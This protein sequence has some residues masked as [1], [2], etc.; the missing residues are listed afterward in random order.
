MSERPQ[1]IRSERYG[2]TGAIFVASIFTS[3]FLLFMIQPVLA[4]MLLPRYGGTPGVWNTSIVFFQTVLLIGYVY[5]HWGLRWLGERRFIAAHVVVL[6]AS[7]L[8]LPPRLG[9]AAVPTVSEWP[10]GQLLAS[11]AVTIAIPFF[12]L[13]TNSSLVQHW[14]SLGRERAHLDP[15]RLYAASN[16]GSLLAL[17]GYPFFIEPVWRIS[18][19]VWIWTFGYGLF[20]A[21][22]IAVMRMVRSARPETGELDAAQSVSLGISQG[23]V[24][25][26]AEVGVAA[27][28]GQQISAVRRIMWM[29]RA[30]VAVSLLLSVTVVITTDIAPVPLLWV[31]PLAIY[32]L[33]FILAFASPRFYPQRVILVGSIVCIIASLSTALLGIPIPLVVALPVALL[34]LFFGAMLCHGD[35]A[36]DRP[37][38]THLTEYYLWVA[39]GG[40]VGGSLN[41]IVAPL[42]FESIAEYPLTLLALSIVAFL[43]PS[44]L[45]TRLRTWRSGALSY[46]M[47][48]F[49]VALAIWAARVPHDG[50]YTMRLIAL[51]IPQ[52]ILVA[53]LASLSFLR[54]SSFLLSIA[55]AAIFV[56]GGISESADVIHQAR[57]FFGVQRVVETD[58]ARILI[59]GSTMHGIQSKETERR[60]IPGTYYHPNAPMGTLIRTADA[61]AAIGIIGLGAGSLAALSQ[62]RQTFVFHEI[63]P[64][65]LQIARDYFTFLE[66]SAAEVDIVLGDGRLTLAD[67][68]DGAYDILILDAFSSDSVPTHLL[69]VEAFELYREK[70]SERGVIMVH[71]SN[72]HIDLARIVRGVAGAADLHVRTHEYSPSA[73][74][75]RE[76][77]SA[78]H[79]ALLSSSLQTI[80][81]FADAHAWRPPD[82]KAP[83]TIWTDD[84]APIL[85][86]LRWGPAD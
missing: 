50:P 13:S 48:V 67:V 1:S 30:A 57:S 77:A 84:H 68:P 36:R 43:G 49:M 27:V 72:R 40:V 19:Q 24:Q 85:G 65:V 39:L 4:R 44:E 59:H 28:G 16:A 58:S 70:V 55:I 8:M 20:V 45:A 73:D 52:F 12:V 41:S 46:V 11:L 79:V 29:I 42:I 22:T 33:T 17:V 74:D 38:P 78:T 75:R 62:R 54:T 26:P 61:D 21:S 80:D 83:S 5:A 25:P 86:V 2:W 60:S 63:D 7:L 66:D 31:I 64:L 3:A 56:A 9:G 76:L 14:F 37:A 51:I 34:T 35:M 69:T 81:S 32:L 71:L 15:Y 47:P 10:A 6:L 18:D 82:P 53:G 23:V